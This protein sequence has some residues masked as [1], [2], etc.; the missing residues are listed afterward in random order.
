MAASL[1]AQPSISLQEAIAMAKNR[2][3]ALK[4]SRLHTQS[5][6]A[7]QRTARDVGNLELSMGGE[8]IGRG[9]DAVTTLLAARQNLDIFSVKARWQRLQQ[10]TRVAHATTR[11]LEQQ[12]QLQV[13]SAYVADQMARLRL[14]LYHKQAELYTRFVEAARLRYDT[15]AASLLEYQSAQSE[16]RRVELNVIEAEKDVEKAHIDL[17]RWLSPDTLY[18][19]DTVIVDEQVATSAAM[20]GAHPAIVLANEKVKLASDISK[21]MRANALPKLYVELGSQMI[22]SRLG[23]WSWSVGVSVPVD[24]GANKARRQSAL[25]EIEKAH[26][27]LSDQQWSI[28]VHNR[29]LNCDYSKWQRTVEYYR[30]SAL[31]LANE[32]RRNALLS[33][34]EGQIG[35]LDFIQAL[36]TTMDVEFSYI[37]AYQKLLETKFNIEYYR[38]K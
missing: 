1:Q 13:C 38:N 17:S 26:T 35:Y 18:Q 11:V 10:E 14:E 9:N 7:M 28:D 32:Q 23:Y 29:Q 33:Y 15:R 21:E 27:E 36:K 37:D 34:R 8:E 3:P 19:S 24:M 31:P 2:Y 20:L 5:T 4:A 16:H 22:G 12:L 30:K 25:V 6:L